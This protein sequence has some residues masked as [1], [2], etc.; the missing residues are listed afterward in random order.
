[1]IAF[2]EKFDGKFV[3]FHNWHYHDCRTYFTLS[4][5]LTFPL[6]KAID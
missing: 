2:V 1:M 3:C 5:E 4:K 6:P